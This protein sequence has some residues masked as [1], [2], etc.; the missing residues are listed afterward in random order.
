MQATDLKSGRIMARPWRRGKR[1]M[2]AK[3]FYKGRKTA[4]LSHPCA[5]LHS[6]GDAGELMHH[7]IRGLELHGTL[8][9]DETGFRRGHYLSWT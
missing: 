2:A 6:R 4:T 8:S 1:E 3:T 7:D 5:S 9:R